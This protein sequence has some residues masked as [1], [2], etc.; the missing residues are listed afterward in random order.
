VGYEPAPTEEIVTQ[1][2]GKVVQNEILSYD[3]PQETLKS[4]RLCFHRGEQWTIQGREDQALHFKS[5]V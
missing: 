3:H 2:G 1:R 4:H 5:G